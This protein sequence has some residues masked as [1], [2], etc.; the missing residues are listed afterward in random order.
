MKGYAIALIACGCVAAVVLV[1]YCGGRKKK[2]H[3]I[4]GG[5]PPLQEKRDVEKGEIITPK[6]NT[7]AF[8]SSALYPYTGAPV[9]AGIRCGGGWGISSSSWGGGGGGG[10][11]GGSGG[12]GGCGG[13]G[14][15]GC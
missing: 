10:G 11:C 1:L 2:S 4:S 6:K 7:T 13:G 12:G 9:D 8:A 15:G 14:G 5:A 3:P